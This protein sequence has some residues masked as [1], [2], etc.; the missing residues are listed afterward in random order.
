MWEK[1]GTTIHCFVLQ[2]D[3]LDTVGPNFARYKSN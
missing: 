1:T 3:V 2:N